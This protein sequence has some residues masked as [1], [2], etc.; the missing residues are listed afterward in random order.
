MEKLSEIEQPTALDM[1][2]FN[3]SISLCMKEQIMSRESSPQAKPG[4]DN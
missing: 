4:R 2:T 1:S 3:A